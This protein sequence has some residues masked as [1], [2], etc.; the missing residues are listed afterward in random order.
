MSAP[1]DYLYCIR[2]VGVPFAKIGTGHNPRKRMQELAHVAPFSLRLHRVLDCGSRKAAAAWEKC[3][4]HRATRYRQRGEWVAL[5]DHLDSLLEEVAP[6]VDVTDL[7]NGTVRSGHAYGN[8]EAAARCEAWTDL[9]PV[10][11]LSAP[12]VG[13]SHEVILREA[14][15]MLKEGMGWEDLCAKLHLSA[16]EARSLAR[17]SPQTRAA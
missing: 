5:D 17:L 11:S 13:G 12:Y 6:A 4:L 10:S 7:F 1:S 3:I 9:A 2:A 16:D 15:A 14:R 8:P